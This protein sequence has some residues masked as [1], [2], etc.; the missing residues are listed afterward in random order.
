MSIYYFLCKIKKIFSP[1]PIKSKNIST[2][3]SISTD[4]IVSGLENIF[5]SDHCKIGANNIFYATN[6]KIIIKSHFLSANG[7]RIITGNHERR[8]GRFCSSIT[9]AEKNH[10][11]GLDQ[12]VIIN[13]DV[14]C[15][16]NVIILQGVKIG[17][18]CTISAGAVLTQSTPPYSI[19]GGV[20][21]RFIK[22]YWSID[23]ILEHESQ[24]YSENE[25]YTRKDL[26]DI[27]E[28]YQ[29]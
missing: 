13:D 9:E 18:G 15:G 28:K 7:V 3:S 26:E 19:W 17:R 12:D 10:N 8:V 5:I 23:Q 16:M 2:S 1:P 11:I 4:L 29:K 27:F 6:A 24:L 21:A 22:F 20:P 14:W 25:R